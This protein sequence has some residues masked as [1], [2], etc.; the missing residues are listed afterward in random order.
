MKIIGVG[1]GRTGTLS[2]KAALETLGYRPCYHILDVLRSPRN[3]KI[4]RTIGAET[5]IDWSYLFSEYEA[6]VDFPFTTHYQECLETFPE[7]K[8]IL[9]VREPDEWYESARATIYPIQRVLFN[10]LPGGKK[11]GRKTIWHQVFE[12]RFEERE[13]AIKAFHRHTEEV[14][15]S[16]A[17]DKLLVFDVEDGWGPIC[18]FLDRPVPDESFPHINRRLTMRV[19]MAFIV[20]LALA[21]LSGALYLVYRLVVKNLL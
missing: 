14:K 17:E 5:H 2:L 11:V 12:G 3:I 7:A 21:L 19:F 16:V 6:G 8:V 9:T 20:F 13:Y 18:D 4:L 1:L 15:R 10:F